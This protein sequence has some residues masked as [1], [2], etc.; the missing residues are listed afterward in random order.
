MVKDGHS[1]DCMVALA[2][3]MEMYSCHKRKKRRSIRQPTAVCIKGRDDA[4]WGS[5][6]CAALTAAVA[7]ATLRAA[8]GPAFASAA[9]TGCAAANSWCSLRG[10]QM[11]ANVLM[12]SDTDTKQWFASAAANSWYSLRGMQMK[13]NAHMHWH[14]GIDMHWCT[15]AQAGTC[16]DRYTQ[17]DGRD[18]M[19]FASPRHHYPKQHYP[20]D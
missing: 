14:P 11:G 16:K 8:A 19:T 3:V 20:G 9:A 4:R 10:I 12:H 17:G 15:A 6:S 18:K 5:D 2:V 13:A 1:G 7:V